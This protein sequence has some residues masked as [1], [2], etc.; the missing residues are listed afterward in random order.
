M[1]SGNDVNLWQFNVK[2]SNQKI[3]KK[4]Y[5]FSIY[6]KIVT[7]RSNQKL[8]PGVVKSRADFYQGNFVLHW[9]Y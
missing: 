4:T 2:S 1:A 8:R 7:R 5:F 3:Y 6:Q 9:K